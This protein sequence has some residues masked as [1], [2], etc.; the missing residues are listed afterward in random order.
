MDWSSLVAQWDK[1]L[2]V[3]LLWHGFKPWPGSFCMPRAQPKKI[4]K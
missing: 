3:S 1:G 4:N 2:A